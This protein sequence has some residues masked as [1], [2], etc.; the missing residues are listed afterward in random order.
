MT[1]STQDHQ[2]HVSGIYSP[3]TSSTSTSLH[4]HLQ[5]VR[6][7]GHHAPLLGSRDGHGGV[8]EAVPCHLRQVVLDVDIGTKCRI[9]QGEAIHQGVISKGHLERRARGGGVRRGGDSS[10]LGEFAEFSRCINGYCGVLTV[11]N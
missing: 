6:V 3:A 9:A 2:N 8:G 7:H 11:R 1:Q 10:N 4:P 5:L